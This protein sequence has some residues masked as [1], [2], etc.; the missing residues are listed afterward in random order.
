MESSSAKRF[1]KTQT[2]TYFAADARDFDD[3][4]ATYVSCDASEVALWAVIS[5]NNS[6]GLKRPIAYASI[7]L[8]L[9]ERA[10]SVRKR[11][12][13][14]CIWAAEHWHWSVYGSTFTIRTD[15]SS[16]T[17]LLGAGSQGR[18]PMRLL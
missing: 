9:T 17:S 10:Y 13:L 4:R 18:K 11:E 1:R 2:F 16:L 5:K 8:T 3:G 6:E 14:A 12:A 15:Y 7:T